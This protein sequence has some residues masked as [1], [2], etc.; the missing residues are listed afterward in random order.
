MSPSDFELDPEVYT[1][2]R[3]LSNRIHRGRSGHES[4]RPTELLHE[5]WMKASASSTEYQSREH[6]LAV[7]TTAMRQILVDRARAR[8]TARRGG[9]WSRVTLSGLAQDDDPVDVLQLDETL[10]KLEALDPRAARVVVLRT[11]GGMTQPE[12]AEVMEV[13][14]RSIRRTWRFAKAFLTINLTS[15]AG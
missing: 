13:S 3:N 8:M 6:F 5:A 15:T 12:I 14:E 11:F 7:A 9:E 4:I 10:K 1:Y 2:L